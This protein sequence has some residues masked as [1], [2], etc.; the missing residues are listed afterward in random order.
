[1][2]LNHL[3]KGQTAIILAINARPDLK[4]RLNSFGLIKGASITVEKQSLT[5]QTLEVR[6]N[7]TRLAL[8]TAEAKGIEIEM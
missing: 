3:E 4:N 1:M 5:R 8:R 6:V 2:T 7:N